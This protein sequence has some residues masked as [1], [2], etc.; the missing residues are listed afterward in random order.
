MSSAKSRGSIQRVI[1]LP[2]GLLDRFEARLDSGLDAGFNRADALVERQIQSVKYSKRSLTS[3]LA[4]T[5]SAADRVLDSRISQS[6][7]SAQAAQR[8]S[9]GLASMVQATDSALDKCISQHDSARIQ[10]ATRSFISTTKKL[11]A[12]FDAKLASNLQSVDRAV[13]V[14][15]NAA[16]GSLAD[17]MQ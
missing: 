4:N 14:C 15:T 8:F 3:G 2:K 10:T 16:G 5:A 17:G 12:R 13:S 9:R 6:A 11:E 7:S 1:S